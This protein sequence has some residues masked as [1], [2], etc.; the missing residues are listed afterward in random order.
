MWFLRYGLTVPGKKSDPVPAGSLKP[1]LSCFDEESDDSEPESKKIGNAIL[2]RKF[3]Y[4]KIFTFLIM[5]TNLQRASE[6][7]TQKRATQR[8]LKRALDED[9]TVFQY[10]EVYDDMEQ[11]KAEV[12]AKK[13][14]VSKKVNKITKRSYSYL[15]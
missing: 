14:D 9:P 10:D 8:Q 6:K 7:S 3:T 15:N 13:K 12:V 4:Q 11:K 5:E 2:V 1:R